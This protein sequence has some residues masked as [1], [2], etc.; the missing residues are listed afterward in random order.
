MPSLT[1]RRRRTVVP[2]RGITLSPTCPGTLIP[3]WSTSASPSPA[4]NARSQ[5]RSRTLEHT[6]SALHRDIHVAAYAVAPIAPPTSN[7][8]WGMLTRQRRLRWSGAPCGW[9]RW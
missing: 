8:K 6:G 2:G 7:T 5:N 1:L 9:G 3:R 4:F